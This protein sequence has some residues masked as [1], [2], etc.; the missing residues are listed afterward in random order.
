MARQIIVNTDN[1]SIDVNVEARSNI[2]LVVSRTVSPGVTEIYAGN[3]I[4]V[5]GHTGNVTVN[6]TSPNGFTSGGNITAPY[7]LGNVVGNISG[8]IVV[9]GLQWDVLYNNNGNVGANDNFKFD[10]G[11]AVLTVVG[12]IVATNLFGNYAGDVTGNISPQ[13]VTGNLIPNAN[14]TYNLGNNTNRFNDLFLSGNTI[15]LGPQTIEADANGISLSGNLSFSGGI[16]GN[17][18]LL[19]NLTGANVTG[20][21]ANATHATVSNSANSVAGANVTGTVANATFATTSGTATSATTAATVTTNAQP[22]ITSLGTLSDLSVTANVTAGNIKTNN[23]L[24][25]NGSPYQFTTNAGGTNTQVQFNDGNIFA[26]NASFT[27]NKTTGVV[28]ATGFSGDGALLTNLTGANVTGT[29]ANAT[30][31]TSAGSA[32]T[33]GTVTT[34]AQPNITSVGTLTSLDVSGNATIGNITSVDSVTFDTAN[35]GPG[36]VA[37]LT[38][39]DGQGTLDLGLKGGNVTATVGQQQYARVYNSE[40]TTL[41]KGEIVYVYGAQGNLISVKRAQANNDANSAGTLGMVAET[42][43]AGGEGFVQNSGAIYKLNTNGLIAGGAVYLSPTTPGAYTQTKPVAPDHLVVLGWVERVSATV[44]SI[45]LK[46]DNG[47][48][49]DELHNVLITSPV[50]GQALV[51]NSSNIWV[52]GTPANA[53]TAGTVT[54]NAQPNIT[55]TGTL[56]GL[57]VSG[58]ATITG[59]LTVSG[60][61]NYVNVTQLVVQDPIIEQG[62]GPNGAPLT[63]NDGKDR[64]SLLHYYT[65]TPVDAFMGWDNSNAEFAF[66][67]NVTVTNEVVT[68]NTLGNVRANLFLGNGSQLTSITGANVTGT[69]ANAT[70]AATSDTANSVAGA[71]VSGQVS[72]ALVAGTVYTNAQPNITSTGTLT[73]LNVSS[74]INATSFTSNVAT[75][76][77]PFVI[78]ST[79]EVANLNV[80]QSNFA[81]TANSVAGANVSG[82]VA[83]SL[84]AGTVYTNAQPNITS[85]GS[86][87]GLTVSNATGVVNFTTTANVTLG[88]VS[89]L[90]ISGGTNGQLLTTDGSGGLSFTTVSGGGGTPGGNTT[91]LQFNNAGTFGGIANVTFASGNLTL[92]NVANVKMTGGSSN[93]FVRTD[94][95][96]NL[97]FQAITSNLTVATRSVAVNIGISN[98]QMNVAARTGN[99]TVNV[100]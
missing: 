31:A 62:G 85:T 17:G 39:N 7:F 22:N 82:Q 70:H 6:F 92:G 89:N 4:S 10:A 91:E 47:Y 60:N 9:P 83:N 53:N 40:A 99:V 15:Y 43:V 42:I 56:T 96:G 68:F 90:H 19:T 38:W 54:T 13:F 20:T 81:N 21:V 36:A 72:N 63:T 12:N 46:V 45:Y 87:T 48:E 35:I 14:V 65:T 75:G 23:L 86:L 78:S 57:D 95:S 29:V 58:N 27:F 61:T 84:V 69:V 98:Y 77:A 59:N 2:E 88:S 71:N 18:A 74:S 16:S 67:S 1:K 11:N 55:S 37:Q 33:A 50:A 100:N 66:G 25:A 51:Y 76:T 97:S 64:G 94:G 79:T 5:S 80:A 30:Y 93:L 49:L 3:N 32:T 52:N 28:T 44:G 41:N 73:G 24:Y 26:G 8:N 34:N